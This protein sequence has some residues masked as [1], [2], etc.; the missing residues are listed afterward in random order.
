MG[1]TSKRREGEGKGE[2]KEKRGNWRRRERETPST[3]GK[4]K[5]WQP[6]SQIDSLLTTVVDNCNENHFCASQKM[7][8]LKCSLPC[9]TS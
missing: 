6:Y 2:W 3:I 7:S 9:T 1:P 5:R 8:F 4:V